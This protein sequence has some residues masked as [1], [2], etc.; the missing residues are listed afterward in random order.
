MALKLPQGPAT[1]EQGADI[2][3]RALSMSDRVGEQVSLIAYLRSTGAP[4]EE[5]VYQLRDM[6]V[7]IEDAQFWDGVPDNL[8]ATVEQG[9]PAARRI[10][11]ECA[12]YG[13]KTA[14]VRAYTIGHDENGEPVPLL[15]PTPEQLSNLFRIVMALLTRRRITWRPREEAYIPHIDTGVTP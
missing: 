11:A 7:G 2:A 12:P 8:R 4:W 3:A 5:A 15:R 6:I 10:L 9:G 1:I 14:P 13:W